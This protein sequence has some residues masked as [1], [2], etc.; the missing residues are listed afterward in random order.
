MSIEFPRPINSSEESHR[1]TAT[2]ETNNIFD[3]YTGDGT[4]EDME[5]YKKMIENMSTE[6]TTSNVTESENK[7]DPMPGE[8]T[9][10]K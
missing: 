10:E 8:N 6:V 7:P 9:P 1:E 4:P 3:F 2:D 5:R